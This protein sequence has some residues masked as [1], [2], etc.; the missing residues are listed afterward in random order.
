VAKVSCNQTM[1]SKMRSGSK[2]LSASFTI[3][4]VVLRGLQS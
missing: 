1:E 2:S 4:L 3:A